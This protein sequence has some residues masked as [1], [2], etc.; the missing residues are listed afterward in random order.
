MKITLSR[1]ELEK[2]ENVKLKLTKYKRLFLRAITPNGKYIFKGYLFI[3]SNVLFGIYRWDVNCPNFQSQGV[4][5]RFLKWN[6]TK[7]K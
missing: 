4:T 5:Y 7:I 3:K 2:I 1:Q 6:I